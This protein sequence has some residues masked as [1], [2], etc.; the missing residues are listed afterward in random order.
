MKVEKK[1]R[2]KSD[3]RDEKKK[4]KEPR[5]EEVIVEKEP[6]ILTPI[7]KKRTKSEADKHPLKGEALLKKT[8]DRQD[9]K[10]KKIKTSSVSF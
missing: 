5:T 2:S 8:K 7:D 1:E 6:K 10:E 9:K 4:P 3:A